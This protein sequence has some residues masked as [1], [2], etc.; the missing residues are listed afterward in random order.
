VTP[1]DTERLRH[2]LGLDGCRVLLTLARLDARK[3]H[4]TVIRALSQ[5]GSEIDDV[6]YLI[7]GKGDPCR[8]Q[9]LAASLGVGPKVR[10]VPY[11]ADRDLPALFSLAEIYVMVSRTD[12]A[13]GATEGFGICYI[14]AALCGRPSVAANVGGA[15]EAVVD[16]ETGL[17]VDSTDPADTAAA[18]TTL[19]NDRRL[20]ERTGSAGRDRAMRDFTRDR[21]LARFHEV[22]SD[23][24]K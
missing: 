22:I 17:I 24:M 12:E 11:V 13:T 20:A 6:A 15:G 23:A 21:M 8:L 19:L 3:G 4:D 16:N 1:A 7:V 14:E 18:I 2:N 9:E 10:I 5:L